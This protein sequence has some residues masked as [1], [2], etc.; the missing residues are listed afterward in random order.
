MIRVKG[1]REIRGQGRRKRRWR[2][3]MREGTVHGRSAPTGKKKAGEEKKGILYHNQ[4]AGEERMFLL[5]NDSTIFAW[6]YQ[7][8]S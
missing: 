3:S 2:K 7:F 6:S 5:F 4:L 8:S 1:T